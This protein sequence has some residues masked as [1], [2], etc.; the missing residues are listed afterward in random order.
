MKKSLKYLGALSAC[1]FAAILFG[2][3]TTPSVAGLGG[4]QTL[5]E[6]L[7]LTTWR[8]QLLLFRDNPMLL[9]DDAVFPNVLEEIGEE[10]S[11]WKTYD[12]L[13]V[14]P[15]SKRRGNGRK[16]FIFEWQKYI[17]QQ[18]EM[19]RG[20]LM[21]VFMRGD[22]D[23]SFVKRASGWDENPMNVADVLLFS[24]EKVVNRDAQFAAREL[25]PVY[26]KHLDLAIARAA[27]KFVF[28]VP[29][30][31]AYFDFATNSFRFPTKA[32]MASNAKH[33][34]LD[35]IDVL[36]RVD[37][38]QKLPPSAASRANY[39]VGS[40]GYNNVRLDR[41]TTPRAPGAYGGRGPDIW[42]KNMEWK[43]V[44]SLIAFSF[45][46]R[47]ELT[48]FRVDVA[49]AEALSRKMPT[50]TARVYID[51]ERLYTLQNAT[52]LESFLAA[53]IQRVEVLGPEKEVLATLNGGS[54]PGPALSGAAPASSAS[55]T[56]PSAPAPAAANGV[57]GVWTSGNS[58]TVTFTL[59]GVYLGGSVVANGVTHQIVSGAVAQ[60]RF[61]FGDNQGHQYQ[62]E[63]TGNTMKLRDTFRGQP[64]GERT[65]V[66]AKQ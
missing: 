36:N 55:V 29:L 40:A 4:G 35:K 11:A 44:G 65:Y 37:P 3:Q 17:D 26:R 62:A 59:K 32:T 42:R 50:F 6:Y 24:K 56:T 38:S 13:N 52:H 5:G 2:Q 60:G 47:L 9:T 23:W 39:N 25:M 22:A 21:D 27:T 10:A 53:R 34:F 31:T 1:F 7:P 28:T 58:F 14:D 12:N 54:F 61:S 63:V 8:T 49:K 43:P 66:R 18:P 20:P 15:M 48:G 64:V 45:D 16:M 30:P 57:A 41:E 46:R 51:A 19:A 33:E